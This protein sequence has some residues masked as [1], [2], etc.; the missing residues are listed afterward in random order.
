MDISYYM[1]NNHDWLSRIVHRV[2]SLIVC[3][4]TLPEDS[5]LRLDVELPARSP[6]SHTVVICTLKWKRNCEII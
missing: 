4:L 1:K 3:T 5:Q 2:K 6:V